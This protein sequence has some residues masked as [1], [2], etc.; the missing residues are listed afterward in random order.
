MST[1]R[2]QLGHKILVGLIIA[3]L[4]SMTLPWVA[5]ASG[6]DVAIVDVTTPTTS[7]TIT[8]GNSAPITINMTVT[9]NQDGT[10][11]FEVY[12]NW[13]LSDGTF[14]GSSPQEFTVARREGSDPATTFSTSGI[15]SVASDQAIGTFT[16]AVGVFDI[17][18]SNTQGGKLAAGSKSN[19]SVTVG[20]PVV[21][22]PVDSTPPVLSLP[23]NVTV[24]ATGPSGA[25]V[26][27]AAT[28]SDANPTNPTVICTPSS[29]STFAIGV[30]TVS[31]E[32]TDATGNTGTGSFSVTVQDTTGPLVSDTPA[33]MTV[34][35]V[36]AN[37]APSSWTT[38]TASDLVDGV[39]P[40]ACVPPSGS[41]FPLG[42]TTVTCSA[43]DSRGNSS[44]T[45][46]TVTVVD[47]A[48]PVV[49]VPANMTVEATSPSG[50]SVTYSASANDNVDGSVPVICT[51]MSGS[52][53][54]LGE[55]TVTCEATDA[56][57]NKG[58]SSF[59][60]T[61]ED[62]T[63]P[64][65]SGM[66]SDITL[67]A[68]G[69]AGAIASWVPPT[70]AD[71]VD[72]PVEVNCTSASG[73]T[74]AL[75][76]HTVTCSAIDAAR[77]E[78]TE[79]FTV[80]VQDTTAPSLSLPGDIT[81]EATSAAGASVNFTS[82]ASDLVDG[83]VVVDC[84][85]ASGSTFILG[86][87]TVTCEATDAAGNESSGAFTITVVDTTAPSLSNMPANI[88]AVATSSAGAVVTW[89]NPT[90]TDAVDVNPL[91]ICTP[92]SGSQFALGVHTVTCK[93][94]D[95][96]GNE[97]AA[98]SFTVTVSYQHSGVLQP[99]N[100]N[101]H[102]SGFKVGSTVPV[103]I[104]LTGG[105]AGIT[106]ATITIKVTRLG[107]GTNGEIIELESVS[108][109]NPASSGDVFRYDAASGQYIYNLGTKG[110]AA[111]AYK[112]EINA[113][114]GLQ[115]IAQIALVK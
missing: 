15:I 37:G 107:T 55:T 60:V 75:G 29:G 51:P 47:Q 85:P 11:T 101:G 62:T 98:G 54:S 41:T 80:T 63:A 67:E 89:T 52:T 30:T 26:S 78:T 44:T 4:L 13:T 87:T 99:I 17:T 6:V 65:L 112:I 70:A 102:L 31:C 91:V 22:T 18:N 108:S 45:A 74:F 96:R 56:V 66:P 82:L 42:E 5:F 36:D 40:V 33:G 105:S 94:S 20:A 97:S 61:V 92:A 50:A 68:T 8:P 58:S 113:G 84:A 25:V 100:T 49:T 12:R 64:E 2:T 72:G 103:K 115:Q 34:A 32:A 81:R 110:F 19:Y 38:P 28:A 93:A 21:V 90:A 46:F 86:V 23:A 95:A 9:G 59:N 1:L 109:T 71:L 24:E 10:A 48:A 35:A 69:P 79:T 43:S 27:Y 14:V 76:V 106:N 111:G 16:L 104:Q 7:V 53:F 83:P 88:N 57:G 3:I 77:N 73:S 39:R 114:A